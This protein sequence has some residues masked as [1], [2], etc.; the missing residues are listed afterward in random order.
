M[1]TTEKFTAATGYPPMQDDLER[2]NCPSA[3]KM[4]HEL[5]GWNKTLDKPVFEVGPEQ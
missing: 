1:I 4:F 2:V 5:C 3:G